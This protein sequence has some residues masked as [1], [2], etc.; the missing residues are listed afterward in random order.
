MP[1]KFW[2]Q[3]FY[4]Q[5]M[6]KNFISLIYPE[7]CLACHE[8][9]YNKEEF[10]C[11]KC[12]FNLPK[13]NQHLQK[14]NEV[15]KLF[16]G[17]ANIETGASCYYFNKGNKVQNLLHHLK[18]KGKAD[19]GK[20]IGKIYGQEL[21]ESEF[22]QNIDLII[23]IPLHKNKLKR[24]GFNQS[25]SFAEGLSNSMQVMWD[26]N[27]LVR[28]LETSTQTN[29]TRFKRWENVDSIFEV[30]AGEQLTNK[31]I[32]LVDDVVTTGSTLES[33]AQT[34]L[35]INGTKVSIASIAC[36]IK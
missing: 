32:L 29:K 23:P 3:I 18:Y 14:Q 22:Y 28:K 34:L 6:F 24:R 20:H 15:S 4:K 1:I 30:K 27:I 33:A 7:I 19:L 36:S 11:I 17:R 35:Q 25:D 13:T 9:L 5:I 31:H 26:S 16:W 2:H 8:A 10:I 21:I 12:L